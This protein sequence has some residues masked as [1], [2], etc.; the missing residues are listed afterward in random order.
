MTA[1]SRDTMGIVMD[2]CDFGGLLACKQVDKEMYEMA[3]ERLVDFEDCEEAHPVRAVVYEDGGV[4]KSIRLTALQFNKGNIEL[5]QPFMCDTRGAFEKTLM[6]NVPVKMFAW[7][8]SDKGDAPYTKYT[9]FKG[10]YEITDVGVRGMC[11]VYA[12]THLRSF[13]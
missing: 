10:M 8:F 2:H 9:K 11:H 6:M 5:R 12:F 3:R 4:V 1:L 7:G 13:R